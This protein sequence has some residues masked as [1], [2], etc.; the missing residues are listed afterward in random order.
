MVSHAG[1]SGSLERR[2]EYNGR[3]APVRTVTGISDELQLETIW[4]RL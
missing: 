2:T 1:L 4:L 3:D